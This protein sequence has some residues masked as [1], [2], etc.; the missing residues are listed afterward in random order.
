[1]LSLL[2]VDVAKVD[3]DVVLLYLLQVFYLD[4]TSVLSGCCVFNA[5]FECAMQHKTDVAVGFFSRH[6]QMTNSFFQYFLMSQTVVFYVAN[7]FILLRTLLF[8]V[9]L[10]RW[11][12][13]WESSHRA[14]GH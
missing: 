9:A 11:S 2:H 6:Q 12:V 3:I 14:S 8:D 10:D 5:R 1:M 4:V 7:V 13:Q